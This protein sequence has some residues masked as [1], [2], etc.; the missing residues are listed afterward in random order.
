MKRIKLIALLTVLGVVG[1]VL[2]NANQVSQAKNDDVLE[3]IAKYKTWTKVSKDPIKVEID[4]NSLA[5]G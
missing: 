3:Q 5:G 2:F 1:V 4:V